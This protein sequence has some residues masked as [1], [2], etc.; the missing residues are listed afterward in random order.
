MWLA[1]VTPPTMLSWGLRCS[2][3]TTFTLALST[4]TV[5]SPFATVIIASIHNVHCLTAEGCNARYVHTMGNG[6]CVLVVVMLWDCS[7]DLVLQ[8]H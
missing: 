5:W 3:I 1:P 7:E 4:C 6:M 8:L 2:V